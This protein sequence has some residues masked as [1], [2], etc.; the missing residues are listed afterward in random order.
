MSSMRV[1]TDEDGD[2]CVSVNVFLLDSVNPR[3]PLQDPDNP[4]VT[5]TFSSVGWARLTAIDSDG[6]PAAQ[7]GLH[8]PSLV[9]PDASFDDYL[10][11]LDETWTRDQACPLPGFYVV[12]DSPWRDAVGIAAKDTHHYVIL[13]RSSALEVLAEN[14]SWEYVHRESQQADRRRSTPVDT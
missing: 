11:T 14:T 2:A 8:R 5:I 4:R 1:T 10:R 9:G 6:D 13:A 3:G 12:P 7:I